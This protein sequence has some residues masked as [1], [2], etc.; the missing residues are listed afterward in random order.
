[1][2][3]FSLPRRLLTSVSDSVIDLFPV[4][5][6]QPAVASAR[7]VML[8]KSEHNV[9]ERHE[10]TIGQAP[11][12]KHLE[13]TLVL[14]IATSANVSGPWEP[15]PSAMGSFFNEGSIS[16]PCAEG[17]AAVRLPSDEWLVLFDGYR[18]DCPLLASPPCGLIGGRSVSEFELQ[19]LPPQGSGCSYLPRH[20]GLGAISSTDLHIWHDVSSTIQIPDDYKHGTVV[21]LLGVELEALCS[22][23]TLMANTSMCLAVPNVMKIHPDS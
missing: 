21:M 15:D 14:R 19:A 3:T 22:S 1:M 18:T 7:H 12:A 23:T 17:A 5:N 11:R 16:R 6:A 13:C 10:W 2:R 20:K 4:F 9:C 8:Y